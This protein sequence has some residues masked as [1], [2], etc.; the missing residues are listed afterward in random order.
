AFVQEGD[1]ALPMLL[2]HGGWDHFLLAFLRFKGKVALHPRIHEVVQSLIRL[3]LMVRHEAGKERQ[4]AQAIL[5]DIGNTLAPDPRGKRKRFHVDDPDW[6]EWPSS[7]KLFRCHKIRQF[8]RRHR[9]IRRKNID[10]ASRMWGAS[11]DDIR[12]YWNLDEDLIP[13]SRPHP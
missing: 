13:R 11:V 1:P 4:K 6:F 12:T 10:D 9:A 2:R 5:C 7:R 3:R 8:L